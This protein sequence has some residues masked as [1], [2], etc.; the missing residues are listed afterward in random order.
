MGWT[1]TPTRTASP[2]T[3]SSS[4]GPTPST[5]RPSP[6]TSTSTADATRSTTRSTCPPSGSPRWRPW[7]TPSAAPSPTPVASRAGGSTT[8]ASSAGQRPAATTRG[9]GWSQ[10]SRSASKRSRSTLGT[11]TPALWGPVATSTAGA[12]T[13]RAS[14]GTTRPQTWSRSHSQ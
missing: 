11:T 4:V 6:R 10:G 2:G 8:K 13:K 5:P 12:G 9:P 7:G 3:T 14:L 1:S